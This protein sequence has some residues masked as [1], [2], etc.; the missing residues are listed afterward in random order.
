MKKIVKLPTGRIKVSTENTKLSLCQQQFKKDCDINVIVK[1]YMKDGEL[2]HL[3]KK[4]GV[5]ADLSHITDYHQSMEKVVKAN[6][7]FAELPSAVRNRFSNDPSQ[8]LTFLQ[9]P[10]NLD[11]GIKLGLL[12][13][14]P[15]V[16]TEAIAS[17]TIDSKK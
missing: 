8:L 14:I 11:E 1:K 5:Y 16:T 6:Q 12:D 2:T 4:K 10:N 15:V 9:D 17:E 7:A 3:N 13:R